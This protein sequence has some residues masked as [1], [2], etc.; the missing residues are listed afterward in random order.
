MNGQL[1][2][3]ERKFLHDAILLYKPDIVLEVGTWKGGGST[4]Q[5]VEGLK[6]NRKGLLFTCETEKEFFD[7]AIKL[8]EGNNLIHLCNVDSCELIRELISTN[9]IPD[10]LFFDGPEDI[11]TALYDFESLDKYLK[12]GSIFCMHDW[13]NPPSI[14]ASFIRPYL[15]AL[16]TWEPIKQ[17]TFPESVGIC[18]WRKK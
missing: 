16:V 17:L 11:S 1:L 4:W 15:E 3:K 10:F 5:I 6:K 12:P 2:D 9:Q 14:K 8:Y 7:E 18:L 13:E